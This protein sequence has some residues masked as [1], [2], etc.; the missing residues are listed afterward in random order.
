MN[1]DQA[2]AELRSI[3]KPGQTIYT[4]LRHVSRSGMQRR[5]S[6]LVDNPDGGIRSLDWLIDRAGWERTSS[7]GDGLVA[8]GCGMDMGFHLVYNLG[9][10]IWPDGTPAP[11]GRRNGEPDSNGGYALKQSWL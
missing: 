9:A 6:L 10:R 3:L 2:I 4:V 7:K 11:H 8:N 5:I 1:A